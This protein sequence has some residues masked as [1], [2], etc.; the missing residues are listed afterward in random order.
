MLVPEIIHMFHS[1]HD[2]MEIITSPVF[3]DNN[4]GRLKGDHVKEKSTRIS[5]LPRF[6][7]DENRRAAMDQDQIIYKVQYYF[8]VPEK[9]EGGLFFG[10]T[11]IFPGQVGREYFMTKGHFHTIGNRAEYYWCISGTG[12]LLLMDRQRYCRAEEMVPGSLHYIPAQSAHR[13][14]NTG[15]VP[16]VF[17]ACWPADA[18]HDYG[19]IIEQGFSARLLEVNGNPE[20]VIN[21]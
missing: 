11:T 10:N 18:G 16:L 4:S 3:F 1:N 17:G 13:T 9:T 20:L 5:D 7:L 12:A 2:V 14:A 21:K 19:T 6:F 8:P 15:T